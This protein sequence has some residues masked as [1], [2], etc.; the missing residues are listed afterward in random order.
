MQSCLAQQNSEVNHNDITIET[1]HFTLQPLTLRFLSDIHQHF[2]KRVAEHM[3]AQPGT[4]AD[5]SASILECLKKAEKG[6]EYFFAIVNNK[7]VKCV[8]CAGIRVI[9]NKVVIPRFWL[10]ESMWSKGYG[11][12]VLQALISCI[13][14][15]LPCDFIYCT[16][17]KRNIPARII[18]EKVGGR[19]Q[20]HCYL[21]P[22]AHG[23]KNLLISYKFEY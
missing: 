6:N 13:K 18:A 23:K 7:S 15:N 2:T 11:V 5:T 12:E 1:R 9:E 20:N 4:V 16:I 8:G 19:L 21:N 14:Y 3:F 10:A 17:D 22:N